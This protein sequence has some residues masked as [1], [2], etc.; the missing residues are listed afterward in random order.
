MLREMI[1]VT[2]D[3]INALEISANTRADFGDRVWET[4]VGTNELGIRKLRTGS[5]FPNVLEPPRWA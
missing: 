1:S 4:Q 2:T 3:T 5:S